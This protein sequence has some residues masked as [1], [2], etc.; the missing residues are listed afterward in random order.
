MY[1]SDMF[2][3]YKLE[4]KKNWVLASWKVHWQQNENK[5]WIIKQKFKRWDYW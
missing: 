2:D 4:A 3:Y 1:G 5:G